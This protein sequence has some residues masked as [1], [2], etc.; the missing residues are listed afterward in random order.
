MKK[1]QT[2][3][4][5]GNI[6]N[7]SKNNVGVF[8]TGMNHLTCHE[9]MLINVTQINARALENHKIWEYNKCKQYEINKQI[10][11]CKQMLKNKLHDVRKPNKVGI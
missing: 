9:I 5:H 11:Y 1:C 2:L 6:N 3:T 4:K 8:I 7:V 10:T